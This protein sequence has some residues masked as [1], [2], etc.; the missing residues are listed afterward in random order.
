MKLQKQLSR[1]IDSKKYV[2]YVIT[3]SPKDIEK[4]G[5][6]PGEEL[7]LDYAGSIAQIKPKDLEKAKKR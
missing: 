2:K 3:I 4:L 7:E 6:A 1:K 5:W